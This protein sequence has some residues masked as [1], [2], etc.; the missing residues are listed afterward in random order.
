MKPR[1]RCLD[2]AKQC[3]SEHRNEDYGEPEDNLQRIADLWTTY[4]DPMLQSGPISPSDVSTMM[5][6]LKVA[7]MMNGSVNSDNWVDIAGYAA[8]GYEVER[9]MKRLAG[10][11]L[12]GG[13]RKL[14]EELR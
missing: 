13:L 1:D 7:R 10:F 5:I 8:I 12:A 4:L 11:G 3:V 2:L 14:L 6:L 9:S